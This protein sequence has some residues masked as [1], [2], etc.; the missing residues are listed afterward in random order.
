M[1]LFGYK[2]IILGLAGLL[3][4]A[5]C[6]EPYTP[7]LGTTFTRLAIE[8]RV[9]N[10][11]MRNSYVK[12][13]KSADYLADSRSPLIS[14]ALVWVIEMKDTNDVNNVDSVAFLF[15]PLTQSYMPPKG[16]R[17]KPEYFYRLVIDNVDID[18]DGKDE[19]Y[20]STE[21][22]VRLFPLSD[23]DSISVEYISTIQFDYWSIGLWAQEPDWRNFYVFHKLKN[24]VALSDTLF[25]WSLTDDEFYNGNYTN[26]IGVQNLANDDSIE[27]P[28]IGDT[29]TLEMWN[30]S[31][32]YFNYVEQVQQVASYQNPLFSG[33]PANPSNNVSGKSVGYFSV[34]SVQRLSTVIES[35][36]EEALRRREL[37]E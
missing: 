33:P 28:E 20:V 10:D 26:G 6:T 31:E 11:S 12:L 21:K 36:P 25:D 18:E 4:L 22:M 37:V 1:K 27:W 23:S 3:L 24:N 13:S 9:T 19:A 35:I 32:R 7:N 15:D 16:Y 34:Y 5:N 2:Y 29:I 8:G 30:V 14:D 17:G